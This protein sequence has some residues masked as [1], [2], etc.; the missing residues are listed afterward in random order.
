[1]MS[2]LGEWVA[3][4]LRTELYEHL[5]RL[6]LSFYSRK[7]TGSLITR[8]SSDTDRLWEFLAFGVVA[9]LVSRSMRGHG[10]VVEAAMVD[11]VAALHAMAH[12]MRNQGIGSDDRHSNLLDGAAPFYTTYQCADARYLAVGALE[13]QFYQ[14]FLDGLGLDPSDWPQ[15]DR[16]LWAEQRADIAEI[17]GRHD[18]SYWMRRYDGT[19]ACVAPVNRLDEVT[20]DPHLGARST[21][22]RDRERVQPAPAPRFSRDKPVLDGTPP[23]PGQDTV[24]A[25]VSWGFEA[26]RVAELIDRKIVF[27]RV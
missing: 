11:G 8:V 18:L 6:S 3:R 21:Y 16:T 25:L 13:P 19:D 12:A 5:Q 15:F 9:A 14:V 24:G 23:M 4:D 10:Q 26:R 17:I 27:G 1:M 20:D 2:V 7:K 22:L